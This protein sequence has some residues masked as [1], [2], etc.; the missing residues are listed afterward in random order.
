MTLNEASKIVNILGK[1]LEIAHGKLMLLFGGV[2]HES[3]LPFPKGIIKEA[4]DII[5][6]YH[7]NNDSKIGVDVLQNNTA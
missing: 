1:Y 5:A 6:Q 2:I 4:S 3:L 7:K